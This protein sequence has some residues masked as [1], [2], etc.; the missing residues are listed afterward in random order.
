M[1]VSREYTHW[2]TVVGTGAA[3]VDLVLMETS[4]RLKVAEIAEEIMKRGFKQRGAIECH[5]NT[6]KRRG[7]I[8]RT[9]NGW[10][11]SGML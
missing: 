2:G 3:S 10:G 7:Y 4:T 6:L 1:K 8:D 9:S 5:L 11:R